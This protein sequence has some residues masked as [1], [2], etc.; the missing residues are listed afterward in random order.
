MVIVAHN[1]GDFGKLYPTRIDYNPKSGPN[2]ALFNLAKTTFR[3]MD[4]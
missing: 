3:K 2:K 4:A 1:I